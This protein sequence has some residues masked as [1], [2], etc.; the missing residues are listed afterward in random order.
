MDPKT[1]STLIS[2]AVTLTNLALDLKRQ[3][4]FTDEQLLDEAERNDAAALENVK[5]FLDGLPK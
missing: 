2:L 4:G 5:T 1:I 3:S